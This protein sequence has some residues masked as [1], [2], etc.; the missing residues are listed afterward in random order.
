MISEDM[1]ERFK[2]GP[3]FV[4]ATTFDQAERRIEEMAARANQSYLVVTPNISH[5]WQCWRYPATR[6]CYE[7]ASLCT[8]DGWPV[9]LVAKLLTKI[10]GSNNQ[11]QRVS[12]SDLLL[13]VCKHTTGRVAFVG[14][15]GESARL[16]A[17]W[18]AGINPQIS[19]AAVE[20]C[21]PS[22]LITDG[23]KRELIDRIGSSNPDIVFLGLGV[24]KQ[25]RLA[26]ELM[27]ALDHGVIM[28]VGAGIE[29]A[30]GTSS[31]APKSLQD[32]RL[33][34]LYRLAH[35]PRKL[36]GRYALAIPTF[37]ASALWAVIRTYRLEGLNRRSS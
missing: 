36:L 2:V 30:A 28:C 23:S 24:P 26:L 7:K 29:F 32:L 4:D 9:A 1:L 35:E 6:S 8:P 15:K 27:D 16:A 19:V 5:V 12:G 11:V 14:G 13:E 25:E 33:E 17:E 3:I 34:W 10:S 20:A 31:R 22:E 37:L 21:P 18:A